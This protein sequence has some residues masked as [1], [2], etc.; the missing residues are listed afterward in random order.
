MRA[1]FG[2][3]VDKLR[4][5]RTQMALMLLASASGERLLMQLVPVRRF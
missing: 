3:L 1:P 2:R 4:E 5:F